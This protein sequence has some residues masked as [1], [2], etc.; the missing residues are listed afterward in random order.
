MVLAQCVDRPRPGDPF[1]AVLVANRL[2]QRGHRQPS[3]VAVVEAH[4][5]YMGGAL[6]AG[7]A[8]AARGDAAQLESATIEQSVGGTRCHQTKEGP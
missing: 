2:G 8:A 4:A 3:R 6:C 7:A 1:G 5:R